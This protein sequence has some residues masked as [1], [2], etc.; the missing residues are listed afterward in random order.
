MTQYKQV[1]QTD[2]CIRCGEC[3]TV[4]PCWCFADDGEMIK[5]D[6]CGACWQCVEVCPV[7][8]LIERE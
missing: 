7:D 6:E 8:A 4:C 3:A 1:K 2:D 5:P